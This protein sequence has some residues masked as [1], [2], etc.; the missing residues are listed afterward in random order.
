MKNDNCSDVNGS[1]FLNPGLKKW[2]T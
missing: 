1:V 2:W